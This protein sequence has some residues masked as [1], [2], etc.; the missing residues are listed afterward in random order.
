MTK[1]TVFYLIKLL[2]TLM[3]SHNDKF[4]GYVHHYSIAP[5]SKKVA[6]T[7]FIIDWFQISNYYSLR[8]RL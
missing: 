6:L 2:C 3:I 8:E 1:V 4:T 7:F 5:G